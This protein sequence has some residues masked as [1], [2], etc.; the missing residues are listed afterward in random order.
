MVPTYNERENVGPLFE[1]I[2]SLNPNW[3]ILFVDDNSPDGTGE[4]LEERAKAEER[5]KVIHREG[6]LGVGS[7]HQVGIRYAYDQGYPRLLTMDAD[8]THSPEN[9]PVF[10]EKASEADVVIGSRY[11]RQD[12]LDGWNLLRKTLTWT[13]HFLTNVLLGLKYD[14]TGALRA[15]RLDRIDRKVFDLVKS[16]SYSFFFESLY[17]INFNKYKIAEIPIKLPP[18][19]YGTS[20]MRL[21]DVF[22]SV[23]LLGTSFLRRCFFRGSLR[24]NGEVRCDCERATS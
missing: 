20:K 15:Y 4:W 16:G 13:G 21:R 9:I 7:A 18:R 3:D 23:T 6:R 10:L 5:L 22:R 12:S 2:K 19:T 17:I 11:L 24:V 1:K 8:F 14:S